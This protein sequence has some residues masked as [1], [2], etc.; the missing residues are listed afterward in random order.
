VRRTLFDER[1]LHYRLIDAE[2]DPTAVT[3][4]WD[5]NGN[6]RVLAIQ[7]GVGATPSLTTIAYDGYDRPVGATDAMG[8]LTTSH[9]DANDN[10][11]SIEI[12]GELID[13]ESGPNVPLSEMATTYDE[14]NRSV[15]QDV[16]FF[17][18]VS[19]A[20]I[21]DGVSTT[22][23]Y[24]NEASQ[25]IR[26]EDDNGHGTDTSY[27]GV[28]R[29]AAAHDAKGNT[30]SYGYD[31][32]SN[33][34][35]V[36]EVEVSDLPTPPE[37]FVTTNT[38]DNLDRTT[39]TTSNAGQ[40]LTFL[41]DSRGNRTVEIDAKG[42]ETRYDYDARSRLTATHRTMTTTGDGGGAVSY[43][44]DQTRSYDDDSRLVQ[45]TDD[46]GNATLYEYD[47]RGRLV[48]TMNADGTAELSSWDV[49]TTS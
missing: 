29:V 27:D 31:A 32:N 13:G 10:A 7:K 1:D 3:T 46:A 9:Y 2:G 5:Y 44:L 14:A 20:P 18:P 47:P 15:Q 4:Q 41:W 22:R 12:D 23:T 25:I 8:N 34:L 26:V 40:V 39:S 49:T 19:G 43:V 16:A 24:Y 45:Q 6:G 36:T 30:T 42:N 35:S 21:G 37:V 17:D 28:G 48:A 33:V 38:F 11:T